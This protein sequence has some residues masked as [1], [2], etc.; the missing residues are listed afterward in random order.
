MPSNTLLLIPNEFGTVF[1]L[2]VQ[3]LETLE[4][5]EI[6][7]SQELA[8]T[9]RETVSHN[10]LLY[11]TSTYVHSDS[12][13]ILSP[14][15][16]SLQS[17]VHRSINSTII[18]VH[19]TTVHMWKWFHGLVFLIV[20]KTLTSPTVRHHRAPKNSDVIRTYCACGKIATPK[21]KTKSAW[22]KRFY[23][24]IEFKMEKVTSD[25]TVSQETKNQ[26]SQVNQ[27]QNGNIWA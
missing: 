23:W 22:W 11:N 21:R 2:G 7:Y 8:K 6:Q 18:L 9:E 13:R 24:C 4:E 14:V 15:S 16:L 5:L 3:R 12:H 19:R 17:A 25:V 26:F 20:K 1:E 10:R 27:I